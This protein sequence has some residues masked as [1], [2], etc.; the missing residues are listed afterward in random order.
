MAT[1]GMAGHERITQRGVGLLQY[2]TARQTDSLEPTSSKSEVQVKDTSV[3]KVALTM[4]EL[5]LELKLKLKLKG[6]DDD[7]DDDG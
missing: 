5:E 4:V 2:P 6:S 7:D 1:R 3:V